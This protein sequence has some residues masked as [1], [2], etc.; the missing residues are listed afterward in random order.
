MIVIK[1]IWL[2]VTCFIVTVF[3]AISPSALYYPAEGTPTPRIITDKEISRNE[4]WLLIRIS[5]E[6]AYAKGGAQLLP[7]PI[8]RQQ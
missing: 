3:S 1:R 7:L 5:S 4:S 6:F 8:M 2:A